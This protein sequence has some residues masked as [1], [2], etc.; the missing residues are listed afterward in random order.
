MADKKKDKP[1]VKKTS[2]KKAKPVEPNEEKTPSQELPKT[3]ML[4]ENYPGIR[5]QIK[6]Y[7]D[8]KLPSCPHC[9]SVYTAVVKPGVIGRSISIAASTNK[10]K[11]VLNKTP[12]MGN[13]FCNQCK[14]YFD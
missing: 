1:T 12:E 8:A 4:E 10:M 2:V 9:G 7:R 11:L 6:K 5:K 3:D 14:K 13:Y